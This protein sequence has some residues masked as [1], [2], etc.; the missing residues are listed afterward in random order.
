MSTVHDFTA[1]SLEG[2]EKPLLDFSGQVLLVVNTA[3]KCGFTPQYEGLEALYRKLH[4]QG[5]TVLG[6][7]VI[8]LADKNLM[9]RRK[10]PDFV[11]KPLP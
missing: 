2:R 3:S 6:F 7:H 8:S 4:A 5:S 11:R 9:M 1:S 10:S